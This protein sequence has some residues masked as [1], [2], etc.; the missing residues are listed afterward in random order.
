YDGAYHA[1]CL[2]DDNP[3]DNN[4][5]VSRLHLIVRA[6]RLIS[7]APPFTLPPE[8]VTP[9]PV[10]PTP[11]ST[12]SPTTVTPTMTPGSTSS[13][14]TVTSTVTPTPVAIQTTL[15]FFTETRW[16]TSDTSVVVDA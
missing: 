12:S 1:H 6:A 13:P 14:A 4:P 8:P 10:P 16:Q 3:N 15:A 9:T 11:G 2:Y 7:F 5:P